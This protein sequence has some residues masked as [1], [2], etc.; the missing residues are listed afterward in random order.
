MVIALNGEK[1]K[2]VLIIGGGAAG[3]IAGISAAKNGNEVHIFEK[4][5]KLGKKVYI[6]GKGRCNLTNACEKDALMSNI[7]RNPRFLYSALNTFDNL[8]TMQFFKDLGLEIK[9]ERGQRVFPVSDHSSDVIKVLAAELQRLGVNIHYNCEVN[10]LSFEN[11]SFSGLIYNRRD[12][13]AG[14]ACIVATGGL[15]Y[16]TTGSTGDGYRFAKDAGHTVT[17]LSPSLVAL[18]VKEDYVKELQGLSL[19]NVSVKLIS[20]KKILY[21]EL[22]EMLFTHFGISGPLILSAS[23]YFAEEVIK[24]NELPVIR[25]DL[26]PGLDY[27]MLE[28][29]ITRDFTE[30][31]GKQFKN[32][33]FKLLP[34][35]MAD[36]IVRLSDTDPEKK[37]CDISN[38]EKRKLAYLLKNVT[39]HPAALRGYPEAIITKGGINVKE[40]NPKNMESKFVSGLYFAGEVLDVDALT[41]GFN[42]QV[43]WSTGYLAGSSVY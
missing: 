40:I 38:E 20:G 5:E 30:E 17:A 41:G 32:S 2:K 39:L 9:V 13:M 8:D 21:E 7:I 18:T 29:R 27:D 6:T 22:G 15:S 10:S 35:R 31:K 25:L 37:V 33:L 11:G 42:L 43:A 23:S 1:M 26:K 36:I 24:G 12:K 34:E 14:D 28:A 3:M 19:K 16:P 4:N